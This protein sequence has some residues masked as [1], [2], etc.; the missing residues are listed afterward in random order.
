MA[1]ATPKDIWVATLRKHGACDE[2]IAWAEGEKDHPSGWTTCVRGDWMLWWIAK[3]AIGQVQIK[4]LVKV[5]SGC[6]AIALAHV[7]NPVLS[8]K[9]TRAQAWADG[10]HRVA[11][12]ELAPI[13]K[14]RDSSAAHRAEAAVDDAAA[15]AVSPMRAAQA[16][17]DAAA[18]VRATVLEA[19]G[20]QEEA[21]AAWADVLI[22]CAHLVRAEFPA[23]PDADDPA[24]LP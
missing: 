13:Q 17:A 5:A 10:D 18:T 14:P 21:N 6:A 22:E 20:T 7:D 1:E 16:A 15:A 4:R 2:A 23:P 9:L 24:V 12:H 11:M 8:H 19:G 3:I